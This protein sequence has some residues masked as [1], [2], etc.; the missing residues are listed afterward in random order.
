MIMELFSRCSPS[1]TASLFPM[2]TNVCYVQGTIS[3]GD[4]LY[5]LNSGKKLKVP[6]LV[7]M[8]SAEMEVCGVHVGVRAAAVRILLLLFQRTI[9]SINSI[10]LLNN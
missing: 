8:H 9:R 6:R 1:T 3:K 4:I 7:R 2:L 5:N 10:S